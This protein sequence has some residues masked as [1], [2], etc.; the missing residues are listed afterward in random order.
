MGH[1]TTTQLHASYYIGKGET[2][3]GNTKKIARSATTGKFLKPSHTRIHPQT[4]VVETIKIS[5]KK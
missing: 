4:T 3:A 1:R 5:K 2:R